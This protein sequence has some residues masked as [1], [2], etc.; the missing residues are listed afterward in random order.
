MQRKSAVSKE[1]KASTEN[2]TQEEQPKENL[3]NDHNNAKSMSETVDKQAP[4]PSP[5]ETGPESFSAERMLEYQWPPDRTGEFYVLRHQVCQFLET[6][7]L[8]EKYPGECSVV[9]ISN[10]DVYRMFSE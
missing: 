6:E 7:S 5:P 1:L 3:T 9:F 2:E 8:G 10:V 4:Q